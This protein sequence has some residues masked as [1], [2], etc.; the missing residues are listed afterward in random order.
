MT[1][2]QRALRALSYRFDRETRLIVMLWHVDGLTPD[3]IAELLGLSAETVVRLYVQ[4]L[5]DVW[6]VLWIARNG[7]RIL[8][9]AVTPP[10]L[11]AEIRALMKGPPTRD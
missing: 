1:L 11:S 6:E 3:E 5:F 9:A 2:E 7:A 4:A 10:P 8:S